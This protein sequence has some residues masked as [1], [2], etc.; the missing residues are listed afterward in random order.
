VAG[1]INSKVAA[2][3]ARYAL[4]LRVNQVIELS[5]DPLGNHSRWAKDIEEGHAVTSPMIGHPQLKVAVLYDMLPEGAGTTSESRTAV[6]NATVPLGLRD[7][8]GQE[9]ARVMLARSRNLP[10]HPAPT[11]EL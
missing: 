2:W 7:R 11:S 10:F 5:V 6:D 9:A 3:A 8:P 1:P 4:S